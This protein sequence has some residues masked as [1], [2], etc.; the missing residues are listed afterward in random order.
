MNELKSESFSRRLKHFIDVQMA[1]KEPVIL[2]NFIS[3]M[4][5][6]C[7]GVLL[8][9]LALPSALPIPAPGY[10]VPFGVFLSFL[11]VQM[12]LGKKGPCL[13]ARA[14]KLTFRLGNRVG[15]PLL[16]FLKVL[17]LFECFVRPRGKVLERV[18]VQR[19]IGVVVLCLAFV[20]LIPLPLTN[21]L[22]A[23]VIF[24]IGI[25]IAEADALFTAFACVIALIV[26]L[27]YSI[28][29]YLLLVY[30]TKTYDMLKVFFLDFFL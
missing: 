18:L 17:F 30:G 15:K 14:K 28:F 22:P 29:F 12:L 7:F 24:L 2:E 3:E 5:K 9:L 13:P 6:E 8:L 20:M 23:G 1:L 26:L 25:G 19:V 27:F 21:T 10:S 16:L 11:G 4:G